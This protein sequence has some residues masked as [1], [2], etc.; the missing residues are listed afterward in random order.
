MYLAGV[1]CAIVSHP[2]DSIVSKLNSDTGSTAIQT[3]KALGWKGMQNNTAIIILLLIKNVR[4]VEWFGNANLDGRSANVYAVV[5]LRLFQS[6]VSYAATTPTRN[7]RVPQETI[8]TATLKLKE[9]LF[10]LV[11]HLFTT[12]LNAVTRLE[13]GFFFFIEYCSFI[14]LTNMMFFYPF[15]LLNSRTELTKLE[16]YIDDHHKVGP[17]PPKFTLTIFRT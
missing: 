11:K 14:F 9:E 10:F 15:I 2:F 12:I 16:K 5:H 1:F 17:R 6:D 13:L 3:A 7:A 8:G 4:I